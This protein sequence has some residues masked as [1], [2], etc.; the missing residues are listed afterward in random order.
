[1][2]SAPGNAPSAGPASAILLCRTPDPMITCGVATTRESTR[3]DHESGSPIG[4]IP[5]YSM[6][7]S[8]TASSIGAKLA[9]RAS[10][11]RRTTP[12]TSARVVARTTQAAYEVTSP[13][14]PATITQFADS[15]SATPYAAQKAAVSARSGSIGATMT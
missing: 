13:R 8:R 6:P 14:R 10:R 11:C 4:V 2:T 12:F 7:V 3:I 1:M 9:L 5:P 15:S